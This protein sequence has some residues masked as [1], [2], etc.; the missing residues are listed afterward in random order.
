MDVPEFYKNKDSSVGSIVDRV[1]KQI[2]KDKQFRNKV[3]G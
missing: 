2:F 3:R 1:K